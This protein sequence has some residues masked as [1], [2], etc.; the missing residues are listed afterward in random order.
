MDWVMLDV[1]DIPDVAVGDVVTI[2][3]RRVETVSVPRNS[4]RGRAPFHMKFSV[5]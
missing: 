4:R 2:F 1:T 5:T 3:V